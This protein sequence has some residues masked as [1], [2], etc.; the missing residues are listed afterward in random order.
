LLVFQIGN[1]ANDGFK[2]GRQ[3]STCSRERPKD[4]L[5]DDGGCGVY[6]NGGPTGAFLHIVIAFCLLLPKLLMEARLIEA[7]LLPQ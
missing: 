2:L 1:L 7:G 4:A 5:G 3:L 6:R